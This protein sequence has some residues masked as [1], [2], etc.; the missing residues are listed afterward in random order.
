[1]ERA[2]ISSV[3][4]WSVRLATSRVPSAALMTPPTIKP[5]TTGRCPITVAAGT[6]WL[7]ITRANDSVAKL[8]T[9]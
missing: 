9:T 8:T 7:R 2:D 3:R 5:A 4:R 1:M 6:A